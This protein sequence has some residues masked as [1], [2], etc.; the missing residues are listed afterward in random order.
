MKNQNDPGHKV[1][2]FCSLLWKFIGTLTQV[3]RPFVLIF[4]R[5]KTHVDVICFPEGIVIFVK[6]HSMSILFLVISI[7][8]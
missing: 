7:L 2:H 1:N 3:S 4:Y 6:T 5:E 8:C